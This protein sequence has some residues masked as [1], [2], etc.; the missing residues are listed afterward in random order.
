MNRLLL[1]YL[2][3]RRA[4]L[5]YKLAIPSILGMLLLVLLG[6]SVGFAFT[7]VSRV[8]HESILENQRSADATRLQIE[9]RGGMD[10]GQAALNNPDP[11]TLARLFEQRNRLRAAISTANH[12]LES[13]PDVDRARLQTVQEVIDPL[14]RMAALLERGFPDTAQSNWDSDVSDKMANAVTAAADFKQSS[15]TR[16]QQAAEGNLEAIQQA[17]VLSAVVIGLAL[18]ALPL[19]AWLNHALVVAPIREVSTAMARVASGDVTA[20]VSL[21]HNDEFNQL[22]ASFNDMTA[23]L[24]LLLDPAPGA[25]EASSGRDGALLRSA[26]AAAGRVSRTASELEQAYRIQS[27]LLPSHHQVL[28]GWIIDAAR[29]PAT[30]LGGDFYDLLTL[31]GGR[32]GLVIGDVSGHGAASALIAAWTQGLIALAAADEADPGLVLGRVNSLLRDRLPVRMFVTLAYAVIDPAQGTLDYANAGHCYPLIDFVPRYKPPANGYLSGAGSG[33]WDWVEV[34]GLPL[35]SLPGVA[36]RAV[37]FPLDAVQGLI[38]Y[39]DGIVEA[40][41]GRGEFYGFERFEQTAAGTIAATRDG[42]AAAA[43]ANPAEQILQSALAYAAV[44]RPEDDMTILVTRRAAEEASVPRAGADN[45]Y[46][47]AVEATAEPSKLS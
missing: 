4:S 42:G 36:Y 39:S 33:G 3:R 20:R 41:D 32:V 35:G 28:P 1:R 7:Q 8:A 16:A 18:L 44:Q 43:A 10:A 14:D 25:A 38:L 5:S 22:Q 40:R 23:A 2:R 24:A 21:D 29:V 34:P 27:A 12:D 13:L 45:R 19:L 9:V 17:A 37:R 15:A 26:Q 31:P 47:A 46:L 11:S 6:G 30:E